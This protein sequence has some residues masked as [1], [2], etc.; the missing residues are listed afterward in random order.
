VKGDLKHLKQGATELNARYC[1]DRAIT[2]LSKKQAH[3][4]MARWIT[5]PEEQIVLT[6]KTAAPLFLKASKSS[7]VLS[8]LIPGAVYLTHTIVPS[9]DGE[10]RFASI[11]HIQE[12]EPKYVSG[13]VDIE[14]CNLTISKI[15]K[16]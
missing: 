12:E 3:H 11:L 13:H 5:S 8:Q 1:L 9:L 14:A 4:D 6:I 15:E 16:N 7:K 10:D 2:L